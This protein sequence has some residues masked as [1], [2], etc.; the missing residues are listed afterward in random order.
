MIVGFDRYVAHLAVEILALRGWLSTSA[1]FNT[2]P[3][4]TLTNFWMLLELVVES[5]A[6]I[7][8]P[9]PLGSP[10]HCWAAE[11]QGGD[12]LQQAKLVGQWQHHNLPSCLRALWLHVWQDAGQHNEMV[13]KNLLE[14]KTA[15]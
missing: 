15:P 5:M 8:G 7:C 1:G 13:D 10:K 2:S 11:D 3:Q 9:R 4:N 14:A 6:R 12:R